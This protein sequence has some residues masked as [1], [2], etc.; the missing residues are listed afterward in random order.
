MSTHDR[1]FTFRPPVRRR[2]FRLVLGGLLSVLAVGAA[3]FGLALIWLQRTM[4]YEIGDGQLTITRGL[5]VRPATEDIDLR[6]VE[7]ATPI[8]L[9]RGVRRMGTTLPGY[10]AG[11]FSFPNLGTVQLASSCSR[12]A[13]VLELKGRDLSLVLTPSDQQGFLSALAGEARYREDLKPDG[14][15]AT[16]WGLRILLL[17]CFLSTLLVP[18][19]FFVSPSRLRYCVTPSTIEVTTTF[20]TKRFS[21]GNC[22]ARIYRPEDCAKVAGSSMPG[23]YSGR[24]NVDGM[25]TRVY[26]T[27]LAEGVLIEGPDLRLYI[28]PDDPHAFLEAVRARAGIPVE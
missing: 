23:Y 10:C 6:N 16:G 27:D 4:V 5:A 17:C 26:A 11:R 25:A 18:V 24:F 2:R 19:L 8:V 14:T 12:K 28:S 20:F 9:E 1:P 7:T 22:I 21:V 15:G 3:G 13:V